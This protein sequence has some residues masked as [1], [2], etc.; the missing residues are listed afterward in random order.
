[1]YNAWYIVNSHHMLT[2]KKKFL[3]KEEIVGFFLVEALFLKISWTL[4]I[5]GGGGRQLTFPLEWGSLRF[6]NYL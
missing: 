5:G 3:F 2:L 6:I 4:S 1:M